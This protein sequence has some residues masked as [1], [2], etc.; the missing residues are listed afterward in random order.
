MTGLDILFFHWTWHNQNFKFTSVS[1]AG[2][3]MEHAWSECCASWDNW[4]VWPMED[5][6]DEQ[7]ARLRVR[8][9]DD[10]RVKNYCAWEWANSGGTPEVIAEH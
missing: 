6:T 1:F 2:Q 10:P 7:W 4:R 9:M 8:T 5:P 3:R